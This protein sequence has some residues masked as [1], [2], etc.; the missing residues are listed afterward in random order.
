MAEFIHSWQPTWPWWNWPVDHRLT[1]TLPTRLDVSFYCCCCCSDSECCCCCRCCC[2]VSH[3]VGVRHSN[4]FAPL[5]RKRTSIDWRHNRVGANTVDR[6]ADRNR[7]SG[8]LPSSEK[9]GWLKSLFFRCV[10]AS[11]AVDNRPWRT[12]RILQSSEREKEIHQWFFGF[13]IWIFFCLSFFFCCQRDVKSF[14][15]RRRSWVTFYCARPRIPGPRQYHKRGKREKRKRA[16]KLIFITS[17]SD[18]SFKVEE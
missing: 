5:L 14:W 17:L 2:N 1:P 18:Y 15:D 11:L 13:F 16:R 8:S 10:F 6:Q 7:G 12:S 4:H 9:G 3:C